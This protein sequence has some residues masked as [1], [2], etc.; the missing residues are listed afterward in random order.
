MSSIKLDHSTMGIDANRQQRSSNKEIAYIDQFC[1]YRTWFQSGHLDCA[2]AREQ[3]RR[4]AS[5]FRTEGR[6][7]PEIASEI[8]QFSQYPNP[9]R[10]FNSNLSFEE[11]G[12]APACSKK[13]RVSHKQSF[14]HKLTITLNWSP[15]KGFEAILRKGCRSF[16]LLLS[17]N[18]SKEVRKIASIHH[19][20]G[21]LADVYLNI[22][23]FSNEK[24]VLNISQRI[25]GGGKLAGDDPLNDERDAGSDPHSASNQGSPRELKADEVEAEI[26]TQN[27]LVVKPFPQNEDEENVESGNKPIQKGW[28]EFGFDSVE[29]FLGK[30]RITTI[31]GI[32]EMLNDSKK[33]QVEERS[34]KSKFPSSGLLDPTIWENA[35]KILDLSE[36]ESKDL[37][38]VKECY[39][40]IIENLRKRSEIIGTDFLQPLIEETEGAYQT[41]LKQSRNNNNNNNNNFE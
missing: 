41:I 12:S 31:S 20:F 30:L 14:G 36:E 10:Q 38:F 40:T 18:L 26:Q 6:I 3:S 8:F 21:Y 37:E 7:I 23:E 27:E 5:R 15:Q 33:K 1:V 11:A 9:N 16:K 24:W 34:S 19:F 17:Q 2:N 4:F 39:N 28:I 35:C 25:R 29:A 32:A 13:F 22:N